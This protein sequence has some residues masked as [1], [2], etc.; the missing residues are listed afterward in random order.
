MKSK[1]S[2]TEAQKEI[3]EFFSRSNFTKEEVRKIKRLAMKYK[4]RL[5]KH[6]KLFCKS[7]LN[8][9]KGKTRITKTHKITKCQICGSYNKFKL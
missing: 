2:K 5:G 1:L 8:K 3:N 9:L 7:C 6:R 4:L